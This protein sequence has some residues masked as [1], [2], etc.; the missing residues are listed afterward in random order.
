MDTVETLER[1]FNLSPSKFSVNCKFRVH[2]HRL[3]EIVDKHIVR[4]E[5]LAERCKFQT[6]LNQSLICGLAYEKNSGKTV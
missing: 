4:H 2:P 6:Y 3:M 1:H 5:A